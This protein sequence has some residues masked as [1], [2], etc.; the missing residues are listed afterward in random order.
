MKKYLK[1]L[2]LLLVMYPL[3]V[4]AIG[5]A[6]RVIDLPGFNTDR[7]LFV[8]SSNELQDSGITLGGSDDELSG[9]ASLNGIT[10]TTLGYLD[11]TSSI[12]TQLNGKFDELGPTTVNDGLMVTNSTD[13]DSL[14]GRPVT[15]DV[16]GNMGGIQVMTAEGQTG[17]VSTPSAGDLSLYFKDD[18]NLYKKDEN[19]IEQQIGAGTSGINYFSDF[20]ADIIGNVA[21][22]DDSSAIVDGTGGSP[23][24]LATSLETTNPL[25]G[26]ASY[27]LEKDT[28]ADASNEGFSIDTDT[29]DR[30]STVGGE[31]VYV[32]FNYETSA[33]YD[34]DSS[35]EQVSIYVYRVGS[36]T[37][38][39]CNARDVLSGTFTNALP[40]APDGGQYQCVTTLSSSDTSVRVIFGITGTGTS[41]WD[42]I[43]DKIKVGPDAVVTAPII[44]E[45]QTYTPTTNNTMGNGTISGTYKIVGDYIY[46]TVYMLAGSTTSFSSSPWTFGLPTGYTVDASKL[47]NSSQVQAVGVAYANDVTGT[48]Q[49]G[50]VQ[51]NDSSDTLYIWS[52][53]GTASWRNSIPFSWATSDYLSFNYV[54]PIEQS[55]GNA[56]LSTTQADHRTI[57]AKI[58]RSGSQ[59][60]SATFDTVD[61]NAEAYDDHGICSG[62][63]CIVP[64]TGRYKVGGSIYASGL[65]VEAGQL[66]IN[67]NGSAILSKAR[68]ITAAADQFVI[69]STDI[70]LTEG[71]TIELQMAVASDTSWTINGGERL[72]YLTI[73]RVDEIGS[74]FSVYGVKESD[75]ITNSTPT[76]WPITAG[77]WGDLTSDSL[78]PGTWLLK[79]VLGAYNNGAVTAQTMTVGI[80]T[81]SGNSG[82]GLNY[83]V[84]RMDLYNTGTNTAWH[85][86]YIVEYEVTVTETTTYYLKGFASN[87]TNLQEIYHFC[88]RRIK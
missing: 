14:A 33:N 15:V 21:E 39:S 78:T 60:V 9:V 52:Q 51:A 55:S 81:T 76:N 30:T 43:V 37:L 62:A 26:Q 24:N 2:P 77:Q 83:G 45:T 1:L 61:F 88:K 47:N 67:A 84:N 34:N 16:D 73:E 41:T 53:G 23:A 31:T 56:I 48:L 12:Q 38:E 8:D 72:T 54:V 80:S 18:G 10:S 25:S 64:K 36:N 11:A 85:N 57:A 59:A 63:S 86:A 40:V 27:K 22:F 74:T 87:T 32:T 13:G 49:I 65:T 50:S 75:C 5:G 44:T 66:D 69:P 42:I 35:G 20:Q 19:G 7:L 79:G 68:N 6:K 70:Q 17:T 28:G 46:G 71:A 29:P 3:M 58:Y 4:L 82:T